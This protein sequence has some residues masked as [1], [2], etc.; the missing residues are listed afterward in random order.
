MDVAPGPLCSGLRYSSCTMY[1]P[2]QFNSSRPGKASCEPVE[3]GQTRIG[4]SRVG[5]RRVMV[6]EGAMDDSVM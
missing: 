4:G 5:A 6:G 1:M 2:P 3:Q